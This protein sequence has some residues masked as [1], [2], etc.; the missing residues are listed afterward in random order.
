LKFTKISPK[1]QN[2]LTQILDET[3][4]LSAIIDAIDKVGGKVYLVGGAVRDLLLGI[5]S[6]DLDME[7]HHISLEQLEQVLKHFGVVNLVGKSFGVLRL[8]SLDID[9]SIPRSDKSG[10]K[11]EVA[12][13]PFLDIKKAFERRDVT[14]NAMGINLITYE[15]IDPFNG[16]NDLQHGIL[17][18]T[19]PLTFIEDPLRFF[20]V[21][22]FIGRF[23]MMPD[24][25][26]DD[27]C[28]TMDVAKV[29]KERI[30]NE[31][32]KLL[33]KSKKPSLAFAWLKK[34]NRLHDVF[35]EIEA[36]QGVEQSSVW[37][38]EGD[39]F[40]HTLQ[41]L[42]AAAK[43]DYANEQEKL[44]IMYAALC[45]D[46]GKVKATAKTNGKI[47]SYRHEAVGV[48]LAKKFLKRIMDNGDVIQAVCKLV[49]A[50]M[51][52]LQFVQGK[53]SLSAYKRLALKLSPDVTLAIL[54]K[55]SLA[56]KQG[57]NP[58]KGN[59]LSDVLS[60]NN[61]FI[62]KAEAAGVLYGV[63]KRILEGKD[64]MPEIQP[65][66]LMG[67]LV[68]EAYKIQLD[69]GISQKD[70]LKQRVLKKLSSKTKK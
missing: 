7:V 54:A 56:D 61:V 64:L 38:P 63:E 59:P 47:T 6:K 58:L 69:E 50:H 31:C 8:E 55:L 53:A 25:V 22:Q 2:K 30:E 49:A 26:L 42:D 11:P 48:H 10:R 21:M 23:E 66:P 44:I 57:R 17:R 19:N 60:W 28:N 16:Y 27:L 29:S 62:D 20:R 13:D 9:W 14:M 12:L 52:P 37:H 46:F 4:K 15:L 41:A 70:I 3:P 36:L 45:H 1:I 33:L 34:I 39:V 32:K 18:A 65:G 24:E 35:P 51:Y 43:L 68:K 67:E 40:E 5:S